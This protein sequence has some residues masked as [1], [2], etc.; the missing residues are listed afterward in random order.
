MI[1]KDNSFLLQWAITIIFYLHLV[2]H[3]YSKTNYSPSLVCRTHPFRH[4]E[5][6]ISCAYYI[7]WIVTQY[8]KWQ[9]L[10]KFLIIHQIIHLAFTSMHSL[11]NRQINFISNY[12]I[13][14]NTIVLKHASILLSCAIDAFILNKMVKHF[15]MPIRI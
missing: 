12:Y 4:S 13:H 3:S 8:S 6:I 5:Y 9:A 15:H 2:L 10:S 11:C 1:L 7:F 14:Y